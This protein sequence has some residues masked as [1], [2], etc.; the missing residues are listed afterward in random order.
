MQC[1][2]F[3][4]DPDLKRHGAGGGVLLSTA[5]IRQQVLSEMALN[6]LAIGEETCEME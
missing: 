3:R 2:H 6:M 4:S 1:D 5:L